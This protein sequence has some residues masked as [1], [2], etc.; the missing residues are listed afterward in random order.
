MLDWAK[1]TATAVPAPAATIM[2]S[3]NGAARRVKREEKGVF[4]NKVMI[5]AVKTRLNS[6]VKRTK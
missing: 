5:K 4:V 2:R 3:A 6:M 1:D